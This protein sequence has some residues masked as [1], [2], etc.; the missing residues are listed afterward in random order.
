VRAAS[1]STQASGAGLGLQISIARG[2]HVADHAAV[3]KRATKWMLWTSV[4]ATQFGQEQAPL[5]A[6][7]DDSFAPCGV[8]G[9]TIELATPGSSARLT[10][11]TARNG[12]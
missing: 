4:R 6:G 3:T 2:G 5:D 12:V 8:A 9:L 11:V 1:G 10:F 7:A